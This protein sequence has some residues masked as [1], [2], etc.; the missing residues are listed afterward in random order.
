MEIE[1]VNLP[2]VPSFIYLGSTIDRRGEASKDVKSRVAKARSKWGEPTGVICDKKVPQKMKLLI[3]QTVIRPTLLYGCETWPMVAKDETRMERTEM[4]KVRWAM[5]MSLFEHR[6]NEEILE[7]ARVERFV[8][9]K[10]RDDTEN[11]RAVIEMKME[12]KRLR[13]KQQLRWKTVVAFQTLFVVQAVC[14]LYEYRLAPDAILHAGTERAGLR[15]RFSA[16]ARVLV[17]DMPA[18]F[19]LKPLERTLHYRY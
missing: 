19:A 8:L 12:G 7:E 18:G 16:G 1:A 11:I 14:T 5:G 2:T 9:V 15:V 6:R 13:G 10:R 17:I 3:Y 4:R